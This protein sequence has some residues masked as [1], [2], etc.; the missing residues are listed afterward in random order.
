MDSK[1]D[2]RNC[3]YMIKNN[4]ENFIYET[5]YESQSLAEFVMEIQHTE[6]W[7]Q[8]K[9]VEVLEVPVKFLKKI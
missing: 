7:I 8:N 4:R 9:Y 1:L 6:F 3:V 5:A 2:V